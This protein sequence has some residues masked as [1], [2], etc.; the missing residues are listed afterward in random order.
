[1]TT[2]GPLL[3]TL[4]LAAVTDRACAQQVPDGIVVE[5][6]APGLSAPVGFDFLPDGRVL[7]VE[8]N[9]ARLRLF[10]EGA[11]VQ[12]TPVLSVTGVATGGER[13]LLGVAVDPRYPTSPYVYLHYDV[14]GT[15]TIRI[16]R[17]TLAGDLNGTGGDLTADPA[18]R[19]DVVVGI[20][21][22]ATNHNGGTLRFGLDGLLYSSLGDDA[23]SCSAQTP[24]LRGAILRL[25][26]RS[27]APGP[28]QAFFAQL[29]PPDNPFHVVR[30]GGR[31]GGRLRTPQSFP[32][33]DRSRDGRPGDRR[34]GIEHARGAGPAL[35]AGP[36]GAGR[37]A[38]GRAGSPAR[39][40]LRLALLRRHAGQR[41]SQHLRAAAAGARRAGLR[42]RPHAA[43]RR[44]HHR[45]GALAFAERA[46]AH[47]PGR[48]RRR[49]VRKRLLLGRALP[50]EARR[51]RVVHRAAD[52]R[53]AQPR[54]LG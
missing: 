47:A 32:A 11:G 40:E 51:R 33:P 49:P 27:L 7:Y 54:A 37:P 44:R 3:M 15:S 4:L 42:L 43:D 1:M 18:T 26:T 22:V 53:P 14:A 24:G 6:L 50:V 39:H 23:S 46:A 8:Q 25:E 48:P 19:F 45:G 13:G 9:A 38:G 31:A 17:Y 2:R 29:V 41:Q 10:R 16:S 28:G 36:G 21:D 30:L 5:T 12:A 35:A 34:R 20:P 52:P